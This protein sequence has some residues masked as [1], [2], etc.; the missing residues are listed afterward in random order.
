MPDPSEWTFTKTSWYADRFAIA[1]EGNFVMP[2]PAVELSQAPNLQ[3]P[4][5]DY[6]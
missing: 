5:V 2:I 4:P 1:N 6:K 3:Q